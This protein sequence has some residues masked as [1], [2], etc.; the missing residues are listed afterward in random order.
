LEG[1]EMIKRIVVCDRCE[2]NRPVYLIPKGKN[3]VGG[4]VCGRVF[5]EEC[6]KQYYNL[7]KES[8]KCRTCGKEIHE[9]AWKSYSETRDAKYCSILCA[10]KSFYS[11]M[12]ECDQPR[13][14]TEEDEKAFCGEE[15]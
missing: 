7:S 15:D 9:E 12:D 8:R 11:D 3:Y 10:I 4:Q 5:C 2:K 6:A 14:F 1:Q 13:F